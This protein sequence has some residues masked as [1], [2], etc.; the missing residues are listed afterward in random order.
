[1]LK[2]K[3]Q[4]SLVLLNQTTKHQE[5]DKQS[6]GQLSLSK[7]VLNSRDRQGNYGFPTGYY[8]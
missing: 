7:V 1:M 5:N 8:L 4:I 6:I 2:S 3:G